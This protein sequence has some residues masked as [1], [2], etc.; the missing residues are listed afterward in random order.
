MITPPGTTKRDDIL[1]R[2]PR[3]ARPAFPLAVRLIA[4][5]RST[6]GNA[7]DLVTI[8]HD[9][10][11]IEH[12]AALYVQHVTGMNHYML[13]LRGLSGLLSKRGAR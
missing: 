10:Y 6:A 9:S 3:T 7:G 12:L 1:G 8:N 5:L 2:H 4:G 13:R 11:V